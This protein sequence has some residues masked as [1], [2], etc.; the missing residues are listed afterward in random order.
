METQA[1][2]LG[3]QA[4]KDGHSGVPAFHKGIMQIVSSGKYDTVKI[5]KAFVKGWT[6]EHI[7]GV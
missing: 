6:V 3:K 5:L 2:E 7:K 4:K 1:Y